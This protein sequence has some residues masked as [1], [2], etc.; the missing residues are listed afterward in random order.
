MKKGLFTI[1]AIGL[2]AIT[3]LSAAH[4][5]TLRFDVAVDGPS[6]RG[7]DF[8][9]LRGNTFIVNGKIFPGGTLQPGVQQNDPGA[10]GSIGDWLCRATIVNDLPT[11]QPGMPALFNT[12][13][14]RFNA[15]DQLT[16]EGLE[17]PQVPW[18]R[19]ITGGTGDFLGASGS[20]RVETIGTNVTGGFNQRFVFKILERRDDW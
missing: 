18:V 15:Q 13:I 10:S 4:T 1:L 14:M 20:V 6:M 19:A 17:S 3:S 8:A 12:Q 5:R 7:V 2:L 9:P 16:V 11:L